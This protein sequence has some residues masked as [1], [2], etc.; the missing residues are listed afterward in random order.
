MSNKWLFEDENDPL[1]GSAKSK[2]FDIATQANKEI[3]EE[4]FDKLIE[5]VAAMQLLL[6]EKFGEEFDIEKETK[7]Y[8]NQHLDEIENMKKGLYIELTSDIVCRLDS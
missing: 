3:V 7:Q 6:S 1:V 2:Y 8:A 5:K 4:E